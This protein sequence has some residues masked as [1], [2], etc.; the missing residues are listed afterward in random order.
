MNVEALYASE[1]R[2]VMKDMEKCR[3][4]GDLSFAF[5]TD[6]HHRA[7][8]NQLRAAAAVRELARSLKLDFVLNGG[9]TSANGP[10]SDVLAAQREMAEALTIPGVPVLTAKGNHDDNSIYDYEQKSG[11]VDHVVFPQETRAIWSAASEGVARYDEA[12][13]GAL[14][15]YADFPAKRVRVVVLDCT[16]HPYR[17][18]EEGGLAYLGQWHYVFS[19]AQ[20]HWLA[21]RALD[22]RER[23]E[24]SVMILSHVAILQENV[25][26]ADRP[27]MNGEAAWSIVKAFRAGERMQAVGGKGE[28]AYRIDADFAAQGA[29]DVLGCW[30]GHVHHDQV[31]TRD[32]IPNVSTLNACTLREFPESPK[33]E[34]GSV[35]ETAF[36]I[37]TADLGARICRLTRFGAGESRTIRY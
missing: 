6:L 10:K 21:N 4:E 26:G 30:F 1:L 8:G 14:Y 9:D 24:W 2:R 37:V 32:G 18:K 35:I 11:T 36:D 16:D 17:R 25:F 20:L 13:P 19:E 28:F 12:R 7:S 31:V 27:I 22:L 33:R 29:R 23:P 34:E 15:Y 5:I 3:R